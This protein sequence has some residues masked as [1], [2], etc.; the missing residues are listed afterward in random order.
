MYRTRMPLGI[1]TAVYRHCAYQR[2]AGKLWIERRKRRH[3]DVST[4]TSSSSARGSAGRGALPPPNARCAFPTAAGSCARC[5]P[6]VCPADPLYRCRLAVKWS[7]TAACCRSS[8]SCSSTASRR[9]IIVYYQEIP[10]RVRAAVGSGAGAREARLGC[11]HA[12]RHDRRNG[13][14]FGKGR[15]CAM[16]RSWGTK[17]G[18]MMQ[19]GWEVQAG[20]SGTATPACGA[21][22]T[23]PLFAPFARLCAPN[24]EKTATL[25]HDM[26]RESR[27]DGAGIVAAPGTP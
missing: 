3:G 10:P 5:L 25:A 4:T 6:T 27:S 21:R 2:I 19:G 8:A 1:P 18:G 13:L 20:P 7:S 11:G 9:W 22:G 12:E 24:E 23:R 17:R 16:R 26:L 15:Q 14:D